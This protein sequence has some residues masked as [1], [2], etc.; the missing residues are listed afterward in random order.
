MTQLEEN[1]LKTQLS[2]LTDY[3]SDKSMIDY[4]ISNKANDLLKEIGKYN[5]KEVVIPNDIYN[6]LCDFLN[7]LSDKSKWYTL[8]NF[9]KEY[10]LKNDI[11]METIN[12]LN[13]GCK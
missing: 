8:N 9:T 12:K 6:P 5:K 11:R 4:Y 2:L 10:Q 3:V 1:S 7:I 13:T